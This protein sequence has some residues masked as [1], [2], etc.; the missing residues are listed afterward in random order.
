[1]KMY[2]PSVQDETAFPNYEKA[3]TGKRV[4]SK[5]F[6]AG[7][8]KANILLFQKIFRDSFKKQIKTKRVWSTVELMDVMEL[9]LSDTAITYLS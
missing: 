6:N 3:D 2:R 5:N 9:S 4:Y 7:D 8:K 1:M